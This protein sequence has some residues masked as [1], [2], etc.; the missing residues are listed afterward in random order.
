[1]E[2]LIEFFKVHHGYSRMKDIRDAGIHPRDI[3][4]A[5]DMNIIEKISPGLY[6]LIVYSWDEH[7]SFLDV[8]K[9]KKTAVI[10]LISA[11]EYHQLST[12][13][14]SVISIAVPHNT[15]KFSMEYPPVKVYYFQDTFYELGIEQINTKTGI[16]RI[17]NAEKT[18]CD[19]F[20]YR[21]KLGEDLALEGLRNYL[22]RKDADIARLR[23]YAIKCQV[24]TVLLPYLKAMVIK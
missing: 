5:M 8:S 22:K 6:K 21:N 19:M 3:T 14:P 2:N 13:N 15:D 18:I 20:R 1:M 12:V 24:K 7:L 23:E 9:A 4:K 10:C 16:F 17:Y 11:L